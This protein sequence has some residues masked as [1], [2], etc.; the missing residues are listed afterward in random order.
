VAAGRAAA[1]L[2]SVSHGEGEVLHLVVG[3]GLSSHSCQCG[4]VS[5][6]SFWTTELSAAAFPSNSFQRSSEALHRF[7]ECLD[8]LWFWEAVFLY[9][10][11]KP[12]PSTSVLLQ[13]SSSS[14]CSCY[15]SGTWQCRQP[16]GILNVI[17]RLTPALSLQRS[18]FT[19]QTSEH[20]YITQAFAAQFN[21][22]LQLFN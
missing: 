15:I 21:A 20:K 6:I 17:N 12:S 10:R 5:F 9:Q 4:R 3:G 11:V 2:G 22:V 1:V 14:S 18:N 8:F 7:C 16:L 13:M 19:M